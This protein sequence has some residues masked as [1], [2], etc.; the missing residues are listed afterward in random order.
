MSDYYY[1]RNSDGPSGGDVLAAIMLL[2]G[3][4]LCFT[5]GS[6]NSDEQQ[7][8]I[9]TPR[10]PVPEDVQTE[11][12]YPAPAPRFEGS[13]HFVDVPASVIDFELRNSDFLIISI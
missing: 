8:Q 10:P 4:L 13:P 1:R 6:N 3:A 2:V 7:A 9:E 12:V 11:P 5:G